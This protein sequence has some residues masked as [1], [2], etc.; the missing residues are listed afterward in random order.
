MSQ[1]GGGGAGGLAAAHQRRGEEEEA[2]RR[3]PQPAF[4]FRGASSTLRV[5]SFVPVPPIRCCPRHSQGYGPHPAEVSKLCRFPTSA[6]LPFGRETSYAKGLLSPPRIV[7]YRRTCA[8]S[9]WF[10]FS[11]R[12]VTR[13]PDHRHFTSSV[14]ALGAPAILSVGRSVCSLL[15]LSLR[16]PDYDSFA[17]GAALI[18]LRLSLLR[19]GLICARFSSG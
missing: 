10:S 19:G 1:K 3:P 6:H 2:A 5:L 11:S 4:V 15:P 7:K 16:T 17:P 9:L 18:F 14:N 13:D 12:P 8:L